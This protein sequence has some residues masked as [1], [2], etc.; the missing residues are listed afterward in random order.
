MCVHVF[1]N[2]LAVLGES[3]TFL[4]QLFKNHCKDFLAL[5]NSVV[6]PAEKLTGQNFPFLLAI[7]NGPIVNLYVTVTVF[8]QS[9]LQ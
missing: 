4:K 8:T 6:F 9:Y 7:D 2:F 3:V 1:G 5:H